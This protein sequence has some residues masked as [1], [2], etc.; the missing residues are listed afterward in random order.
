[1]FYKCLQDAAWDQSLSRK[2]RADASLQLCYASL[3]GFGAAQ[4]IPAALESIHNA[5]L[6]GNS[7]AC[8]LLR[9]IYKA[10]GTE[11]SSSL[12]EFSKQCLASAV[13]AGSLI[14]RRELRP[15][16]RILLRKSEESRRLLYGA[17]SEGKVLSADRVEMFYLPANMAT[18]KILL[19]H[20]LDLRPPGALH[21]IATFLSRFKNTVLHAG[22]ALGVDAEQF[23][24]A[25]SIASVRYLDLQDEAGNAPLIL[26]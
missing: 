6:L 25:L 24:T 11:L 22:A 23:R 7:T 5:A 9:R 20:G 10:T 2:L 4:N 19:Q 3:D 18:L 8:G 26:Q 1:M 16:D 15:L 13:I 21:V 14:A 12:E 17:M